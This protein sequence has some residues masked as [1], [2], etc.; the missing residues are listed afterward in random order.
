MGNE[1]IIPEEGGTQLHSGGCAPHGFPK[2][3]KRGLWN[4][5]LEI[6]HLES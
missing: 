2:V 4:K 3:E 6:F 1:R 5:N